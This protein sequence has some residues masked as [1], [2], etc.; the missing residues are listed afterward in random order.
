M[1]LL[2]SSHGTARD[3]TVVSWGGKIQ[4]VQNKIYFKPF[5]ETSKISIA[6]PAWDGGIALLRERIKGQSDDWDVVQIDAAD[7]LRGC[8]E[9]LFEQVNWAALGGR[10]RYLKN[11]VSDCGVGSIVYSLVL[12]YD[13]AKQ[14]KSPVSWKD[15]WDQKKFPGKRGMKIGPKANLEIALMADGVA[16]EDVYPLLSTPRGIERAFR[17]L[18]EIKQDLVWWEKGSDPARMLSAN[19]VAMTTAYNTRISMANASEMKSFKIEWTNNLYAIDSWA[20]LKGSSHKAEAEQFLAYVSRP[21]IQ[22]N[23]PSYMPYGLTHKD[24]GN[25]L[26]KASVMADL[27]SNSAYLKT[28]LYV[29]EEFWA[30]NENK[31]AQRFKTWL[32]K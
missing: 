15:F 16:P 26:D 10:E 28:A 20:I 19:E 29:D 21:D 14:K 25:L 9:G 3:L 7:L 5:S 2:I 30:A 17:K 18:D 1:M 13:P 6:N 24:A 4:E 27:P 8:R 23:L 12:A 22:K 32:L 11:A 31:L